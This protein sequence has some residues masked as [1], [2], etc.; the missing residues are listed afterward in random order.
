L[1]D[2]YRGVA[3]SG[4]GLLAVR[5]ALEDSR[6]VAVPDFRDAAARAAHAADD[7]NPALI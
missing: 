4:V 6:M 2:V 1:L 3:M 5:S 7:W